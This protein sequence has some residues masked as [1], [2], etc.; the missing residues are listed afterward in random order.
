MLDFCRDEK[1]THADDDRWKGKKDKI[2]R[3]KK[4]SN[5]KKELEMQ[6]N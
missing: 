5:E 4:K 6:K 2:I 3:I 1:L